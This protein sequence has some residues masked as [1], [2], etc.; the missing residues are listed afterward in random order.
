[1]SRFEGHAGVSPSSVLL[2]IAYGKQVVST[3]P[4]FLAKSK[5]VLTAPPL[6][7]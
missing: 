6:Q 2:V 5:I 1:V 7:P 3:R 4:S